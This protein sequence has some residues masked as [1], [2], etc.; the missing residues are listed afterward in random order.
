MGNHMFI[1]NIVEPAGEVKIPHRSADYTLLP[2]YVSDMTTTFSKEL[3]EN[4]VCIPMRIG[5][6]TG[7]ESTLDPITKDYINT[8]QY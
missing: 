1:A 5:M 8:Y 4:P 7:I 6:H 2:T 3:N